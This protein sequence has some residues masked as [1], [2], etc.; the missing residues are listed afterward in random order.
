MSLHRRVLTKPDGRK[1]WL[2][3]RE[4]IEGDIAAPSP[5]EGVTPNPHLRWHPLR[6]EWVAYAGHRQTRT[7]LP[8][9]EYDPLAPTTDPQNPTEL[10]VG[11]Y[12]VAVFENRFPTL[13]EGAHDPPK[14]I[15]PT[16]PARGAC[17]VI[18]YTQAQKG[19]LGEL[20]LWHVE[21]VLAAWTDRTRELGARDDV[22]YVMPFENRGVEVGVTL[23]HPHGQLYAYPFVPP[24]PARELEMMRAHHDREK[25]PLLASLADAE[26][27]EGARLVHV[28]EHALA[29][30]PAFARYAYEVWVMPRRPAATLVELS[31]EE[32]LGLARTLKTVL[33]KLDGLWGVPMPYVMVVHQA[34]VDG[35]LHPEAHVHIE[36][37]SYFRMKGRLKYLAG[38]EIGAG[39]FTADTFPED[40]AR[41]LV[42]V[43]VS[44]EGQSRASMQSEVRRA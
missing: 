33:M 15:V 20:P 23:H 37:Y 10:P 38:S 9:A 22:Q 32:R 7:F 40:K 36:I 14:A 18:V 24:V 13:Y 39:A 6:G 11:S 43:P 30:V 27:G 34:P 19:S 25:R 16:L 4:P 35:K 41:E 12:D 2:Y 3:G 21:M 44:F 17:E 1:L 8:P 29:F 5:G 26:L 42:A 28:D 31:P